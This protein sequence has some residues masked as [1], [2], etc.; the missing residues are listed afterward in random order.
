MVGDCVG[1]AL[2]PSGAPPHG[3]RPVPGGVM[4]RRLAAVAIYRPAGGNWCVYLA[5]GGL[6]AA[7]GAVP[8]ADARRRIAPAR[9]WNRHPPSPGHC[10]HRHA[11]ILRSGGAGALAGTAR[12]HPGFAQAHPGRPAV[13]ASRHPRPV[14]AAC[15]GHRADGRDLLCGRRRTHRARRC[16]VRLER[17]AGVAE[18]ARRCLDHA[19][20][21][22][23]AAA[24]D[25]L[26]C[27]QQGCRA[28]T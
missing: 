3:D 1:A 28:G 7:H 12:A 6:A 20:H 11:A 5:R 17:H 2:A 9:S 26:R 4:G 13:A 23:G 18:R 8:L 14:G 27:R 16:C 19:A 21:L 10:P 15:A 24:G 22:H 25:P